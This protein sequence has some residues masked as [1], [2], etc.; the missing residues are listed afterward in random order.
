MADVLIDWLVTGVQQEHNKEQERK[1]FYFCFF[2]F[3]WSNFHPFFIFYFVFFF[4]V[5]LF[6]FVVSKRCG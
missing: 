3:F 1:N 5:S 4:E 6:Y 2:R